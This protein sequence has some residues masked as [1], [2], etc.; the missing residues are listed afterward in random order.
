MRISPLVQGTALLPC[1]SALAAPLITPRAVMP[2][3]I[4]SPWVTVDDAGR[5]VS[6]IYPMV[7]IANGATSTVSPAPEWAVKTGTWTLT[8][9]G[10]HTITSPGLAP[11]ASPTGSGKAGAFLLCSNYQQADAPFC[12]PQAGTVMYPGK[13]YYREFFSLPPHPI[14]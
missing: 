7:T 5:G 12:M 11:T 13:T 9:G 8:I 1:V 14:P 3:A 6:T 2:R 10:T 4:P